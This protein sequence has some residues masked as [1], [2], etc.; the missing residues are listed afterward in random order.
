MGWRALPPAR[1]NHWGWVAIRSTLGSHRG[2]TTNQQGSR[3]PDPQTTRRS[4]SQSPS[5]HSSSAQGTPNLTQIQPSH[6]PAQFW[7]A[8]VTQQILEAPGDHRK[9]PS[10]ITEEAEGLE[11]RRG[12]PQSQ[13]GCHPEWGTPV[14]VLLGRGQCPDSSGHPVEDSRM[15]SPTSTCM[16]PASRSTARARRRSTA[17]EAPVGR[18]PLQH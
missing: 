7:A 1:L 4:A 3:G 13:A 8:Y 17:P 9:S 2:H 12:L 5:A 6:I 10:S 14:P 16:T 18:G 11:G 15:N